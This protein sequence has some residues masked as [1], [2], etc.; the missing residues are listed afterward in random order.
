[1]HFLIS[2]SHFCKKYTKIK[3]VKNGKVK[4][5]NEYDK[6]MN[7]NVKNVRK[8]KMTDWVCFCSN[9]NNNH[10][11]ISFVIIIMI[12]LIKVGELL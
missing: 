11:D 8:K 9:W 6:N 5:G 2:Y 7:L 10:L 1:M 4:I 12:V 3:N